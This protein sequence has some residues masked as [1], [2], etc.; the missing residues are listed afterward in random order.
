MKTSI[1]K[2]AAIAMIM[3][4][5]FSCTSKM[6]EVDEEVTDPE[7][8]ILGKWEL[9]QLTGG[10]YEHAPEK[11][12]PTGYVEYLHDGR[13]GWYDYSTKEYI[14]YEGLYWV[15]KSYRWS[16]QIH[17]VDDGWVLHYENPRVYNEEFGGE[18]DKYKYHLDKPIGNQFLLHFKNHDTMSLYCLELITGIRMPDYIYKRKK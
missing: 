11:Y 6:N 7:T 4:G 5:S 17:H 2:F 15:D 12:T 13:F 1:F 8:A 16:E 10:V 18:L 14:L 3:A 9:V